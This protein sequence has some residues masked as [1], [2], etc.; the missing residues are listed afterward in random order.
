MTHHNAVTGSP[1]LLSGVAT[2]SS[3]GWG[4]TAARAVDGEINQQYSGNSCTHTTNSG[5]PWWKLTLAT[6]KQIGKVE[7]WNRADCCS[8]RLNGVQVKVDSQL[9]GTLD[10][11]TGMQTVHCNK[12]GSVME[13]KMPRSDY[14]SLC[15][16]KVYGG[17]EGDHV[18]CIPDA[19][20]TMAK[21]G[22][23]FLI[24]FSVFS[25]S[26]PTLF[27]LVLRV[28]LITRIFL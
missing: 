18:L 11:S 6:P 27:F 9:C 5:H 23:N 19:Y 24:L 20:L 14:L 25:V 21:E 15:E 12:R 28:R 2:Q 26:L 8:S 3:E 7:V 1:T 4:G 22:M 10:A 16:V 17:T 13:I